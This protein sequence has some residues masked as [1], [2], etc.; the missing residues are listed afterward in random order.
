MSDNYYREAQEVWAILGNRK[1][2]LTCLL[3]RMGLHEANLS[4]LTGFNSK[5]KAWKN[6]LG[7]ILS[8]R[9][10]L[11]HPKEGETHLKEG[12]DLEEGEE[13][14]QEK[15]EILKRLEILQ[16]RLLFCVQGLVRTYSSKSSKY[17]GNLR[18]WKAVEEELKK[19]YLNFG[20]T[21]KKS[22]PQTKKPH[23]TCLDVSVILEH[24]IC[25]FCDKC[26]DILAQE[27]KAGN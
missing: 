21:S 18:E 14:T 26:S 10:V 8:S 9:Q 16:T 6:I 22:T 1:E 4:H 27:E 12:S 23:E 15:E 17:K 2:F 20:S 7:L 19:G 3:E 11:H 24:T 25:S 13:E 5:L